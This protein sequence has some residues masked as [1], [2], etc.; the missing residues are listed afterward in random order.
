MAY[1]KPVRALLRDFA[2]TK[3]PGELFTRS[4]I[5]KWVQENHPG[6]RLQTADRQTTALTTNIESR[7][8]WYPKVGQDDVF[9][10]LRPNA[11]DLRL[12]DAANDPRPFYAT[13][14][15]AVGDDVVDEVEEDESEEVQVSDGKRFALEHHLRDF[16]AKDVTLIEPGMILFAEIEGIDGVEVPM[17]GSRAA[18]ILAVD[19]AGNLVVIEL[20]VSR[21]HEKT[22]GQLLR[23]IGFAKREYAKGRKVRGIIVASEISNDL[24]LAVEPLQDALDVRLMKYTLKFE[25]SVAS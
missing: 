4:D 13:D 12:F 2:S 25:M 3:K 24:R 11:G 6:V 1:D 15:T 14:A 5:R 8:F 18:D 21:G 16:L 10:R 19:P 17:G 23:Y 7:R 20:K 9:F 22:V